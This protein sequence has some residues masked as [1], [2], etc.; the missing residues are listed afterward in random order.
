MMYVDEGLVEL[1]EKLEETLQSL[2]LDIKG[3][4]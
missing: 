2:K 4:A 1:L 3:E